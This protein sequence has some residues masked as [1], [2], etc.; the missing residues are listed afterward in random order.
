MSKDAN[1]FDMILRSAGSLNSK[2][3]AKGIGVTGA[4]GFG[5]AAIGGISSI[6]RSIKKAP[7]VY[8]Q[9]F[10]KPGMASSYQIQ[11]DPFASYRF[12]GRKNRF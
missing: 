7:T 4:L 6:S 9:N 8:T 12:L 5:L 11:A 2:N 1:K 10:G 3:L